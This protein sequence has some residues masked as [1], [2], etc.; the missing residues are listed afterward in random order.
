MIERSRSRNRVPAA[1]R[2]V[3]SAAALCLAGSALAQTADLVVTN[4]KVFTAD[5]ASSLAQAFAVKDGRFIAV[6]SA[7][8]MQKLVG[9]ATKVVDLKGRFV[10]PGLS[11]GHFHNE[12]GGPGVDLSNARSLADL[13]AAVAA[14]AK[15]AVPGDLIVSN[16]D[17]HEAQLKEQRLPTAAEL[18]QVSPGN[19]VVLVRGGH[20]YILNTAALRKYNIGKDTPEPAGGAITRDA[21]GEL[22]GEL[23]DNAKNL[24]T[25]PSPRSV[26]V[27]DVLTTQRRLNAY[28]ITSV[29]VPG[30]YKGEFPR[31][32]E[33]IL[34]A[35][36]S[37]QLSLRYTIYLPGFGVRQ[38]ERIREIIANSP[39]KQDEG[40][41]W[42][43]IGGIKL[44]VDGG[45]EGGHMSKPFAGAYG[46]GGTFYGLMVVPQADFTKVIRAINDAGWR[47]TTHAVGD[48]GIDE[49]LEAYEAA[50]AD[51]P[52]AG[53]RWAI[54]HLFVSRPEQLERM[55]KL[56]LTLSVQDHLYLAAPT[57]K[58]YLG[59]ERASQV[60]PVKT[61]VDAGFLV[62]GGTDSPV[63]P[64]NPF[65][66]FY[67]FLTRDTIT[68]GVYGANERVP[69]RIDLL[70][71]ITINYAKATGEADL[72][73]SIEAG[74]LADFAVL[75]DDLLTVAESKI[76][77]MKAVMTYVGGREVYRDP[78][79]Q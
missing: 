17:W 21:A 61:Y 50:N 2:A 57:L 16:G 40:D 12:G 35:R 3:I 1:A 78:S 7:E 31:A 58:N 73:G 42:V 45:F 36:K 47:A 13:T 9:A 60:T 18:D 70:R 66:E 65:W 43:R 64:F 14:A 4:G 15:S 5:A 74:K 19:P 68:D 33:A 26:T 69:S 46:K 67:H 76:P 28:G 6:G 51:H 48:A 53:K 11:D 79:V 34:A 29:R 38:P 62:I 54:E 55:K 24:V 44:L 52:L 30:A 22:T 39:L 75:T 37:G 20:D 23:V 72:K 49:V 27:D 32:L 56:D 63:V 59:M 71:M 8:A 41:E 10:T 77:Q 25:L